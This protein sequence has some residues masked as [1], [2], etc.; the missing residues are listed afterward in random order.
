MALFAA[1]GA[2]TA[3]SGVTYYVD[4]TLGNDA[5]DGQSPST[6]WR[7]LARVSQQVFRP[8]DSILLKRGTTCAG[9][10]W[11][12]GSGAAE[13]TITIGA[14]GDGPLPRIQSGPDHEAALKLFNQEYWDIEDL[15][16]IG[17]QPHGLFVSGNQGILHHVHV[18]NVMVHDVSGDVKAK[19]GGLLVIS[20]G[21]VEQRFDDV[22]VDGVTAYG[23]SQWAGIL[24]GGGDFGFPPESTF[25]TNVVV[26]NS[27]VH[28]VQGDGI[29]LF[30]INNG[31]IE[32]SVSWNTGMQETQTIGTPNAIW[33]W[34]CR[35]CT[36]R[37]NEAF[38]S[39]SPGVDGGAF[40]IDYGNTDNTVEDNYGHD[41]QGYCV[42]VFGAGWTTVNSVVRH[43]V[44]ADNGRSPRLARYQGALFLW[45]WNNGKLSGLRIESNRIYWNPAEDAPALIN[46]ATFE[47][48][49]WFENNVIRSSAPS[50][51]ASNASLKL[52]GNTYEYTGAGSPAWEYGAKSY[53][54]F[55][56]YQTGSGQDAHG[57]T[58]QPESS[59]D[60]LPAGTEAPMRLYDSAGKPSAWAAYEGKW[61]L[62]G[63]VSPEGPAGGA[64]RGQ[65][66]FLTSVHEQF[67]PSGLQVVIMAELPLESQAARNLAYDWNLR[68]IP[69]LVD[70]G[71]ALRDCGLARVP[72]MILVSPEK[73]IVWHTDGAV[74]PGELGLAL[75]SALGEPRYAQMGAPEK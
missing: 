40:D 59:D 13:A 54:S 38:L 3:R 5:A 75:R 25:S 29:I 17:G 69:V 74:S 60:H 33:T 42:A 12:K 71:S 41:T 2:P 37:R 1:A 34:M 68:D 11:P 8:G 73:K 45:S 50:L 64:S 57:R 6:G 56:A 9:M 48:S 14:W 20:P 63:F 55:Q 32:N 36:V 39:D 65:V 15:E 18:R 66:A 51:I 53:R 44:C 7:S 72:S 43:N 22:V 31:V 47:G 49:G 19:E 58:R 21:K 30:R 16:L 26:R 24:V 62:A 67:R 27:I 52:D 23:T 10:L 46:R 28:D 35:N 4:C 70:N 61:L